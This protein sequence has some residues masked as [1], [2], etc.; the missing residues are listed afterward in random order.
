MPSQAD[1]FGQALDKLIEQATRA[2]TLEITANL[3]E[4]CPVLTG[5]CRANFIPGLG[6]DGT[7][8]EDFS[9][10]AQPAGIAAVTAWTLGDGPLNISNP[11]PY[12]GRLIAGSSSQAPPGWDLVA[13]DTA[14]ATVQSEYDELTLTV[15]SGGTMAIRGG[16]AAS[17]LASAYSPFGDE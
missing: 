5:H 6:E 8:V 4:S 1:A 15:N 9:G 13:I 10:T 12:L 11:T 17:N 7:D 2:L 16:F 14:V 3:V